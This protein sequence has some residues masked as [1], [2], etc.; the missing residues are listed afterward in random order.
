MLI[1]TRKVGE[2]IN[3]GNDIKVTVVS[4]EGG[5]VRLGIEA[6]R[7]VIVHREEIFN[8]ILE[9]NRQAAKTSKIDLKAIAKQWK[10]RRDD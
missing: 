4:L 7:D 8:K 6:P 1:L 9:E 2:S 5:Q 3:I 10:A